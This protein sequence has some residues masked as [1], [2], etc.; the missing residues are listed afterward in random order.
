LAQ[1]RRLGNLN[2]LTE[3]PYFASP[4]KFVGKAGN[5]R[6][7]DIAIEGGPTW[8]APTAFWKRRITTIYWASMP[9]GAI[10]SLDYDY[11]NRATRLNTNT[12]RYNGDGLRVQKMDSQGAANYVYDGSSLAAETDATGTI[13]AY[14]TPGGHGYVKP[15]GDRWAFYESNAIGSTLAVTDNGGDRQAR[16]QYDAFGN[17]NKLAENAY[18]ASP[19]KYVGR[20]GYYNDGDSGM[21][22]LGHRYY[23]PAIGRFLT[24]DPIGHEGGLNLYAYCDNDPL[25]DIDPDGLA[26][27]G[28]GDIIG[29]LGVGMSWRDAW[30]NPSLATIGGA[31]LDSATELVP[32]IP[33]TSVLRHGPELAKAG[34]D[35]FVGT[36]NASRR[37]SIKSGLNKTH[38]P[39]H[40]V[41]DA[42]SD[43]SHGKGVTINLRKD[44]HRDT[45]TNGKPARKLSSKRSHLAADVGELRNLLKQNNYQRPVR[46][47]Q[48]QELVRQNKAAGGFEKKK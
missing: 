31:I 19:H 14:Y 10:W 48:L 12:F 4:Y 7:P 8:P 1:V 16:Y 20:E 3:N 32:I 47:R 39:H 22:L 29:W 30:N 28:P 25:G 9:G 38:T 42:V 11:E 5:H 41:Q 40:A 6:H 18:F 2:K 26:P 15:S 34:E 35:L 27:I 43:T 17:L 37:A 23:L 21:L 36:Y 46:N 24:P 33:G 44:I 13:T 45:A